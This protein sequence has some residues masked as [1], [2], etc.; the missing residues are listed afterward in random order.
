MS[1]KYGQEIHGNRLLERF[2]LEGV[3]EERSYLWTA[4]KKCLGIVKIKKEQRSG[5]D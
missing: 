5:T 4:K 3:P 1:S 2:S